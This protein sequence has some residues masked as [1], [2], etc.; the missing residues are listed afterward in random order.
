MDPRDIRVNN[1]TEALVL[2]QALAMVRERDETAHAAADGK[3][4]QELERLTLARG[5]ELM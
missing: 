4:L 1:P 2:A 5:R 3:V